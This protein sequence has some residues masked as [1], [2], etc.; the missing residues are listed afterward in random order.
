LWIEQL[1]AESTGKEGK[2]ILPIAGEPPVEARAYGNDRV[3]VRFRVDGHENAEDSKRVRELTAAGHPVIEMVLNDL[4]DLSDIFYTW[5]FATA[6]AGSFLGIDPFDQP[7]VQESKDNTKQLLDEYRSK[8]ALPARTAVASD[9]DMKVFAAEG[10]KTEASLQAA[11]QALLSK[12]K[13]GDYVALTE[14]IDESNSHDELISQIRSHLVRAL[15]VATTSGYGPRFLHSTGQLHKG[16][17]DQGVFIQITADDAEDV[18]IPGET[19]TFSVLKQA[20]AIG[21]FQSLASRNRRAIN[22][23][24][25]KD[26]V[27]GLRRLASA[28]EQAVSVTL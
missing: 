12:V 7:N 23:H 10:A 25:G 4:Y 5:E 16:G 11:V 1:V 6:I 22:V 15:H 18:K 8:G 21:D 27:A 26:S 24:L 28:I 17:S 9:G 20:Q 3:F 19:F 2:G 13:A 14:Y